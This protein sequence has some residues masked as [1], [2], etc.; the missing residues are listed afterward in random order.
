[1]PVDPSRRRKVINDSEETDVRR[2]RGEVG[3][4]SLFCDMSSTGMFS[5]SSLVLSAEGSL[6]PCV[7]ERGIDRPQT[8]VEV[9]Q[10]VAV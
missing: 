2:A 7:F 3:A 9:R 10:E 5:N 1:M 4:S 6:L 8:Q